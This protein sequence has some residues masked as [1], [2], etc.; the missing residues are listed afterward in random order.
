MLS[1]PT[2]SLQAASL[3][4]LSLVVG[5]MFGIWRGYDPG[6]YSASTFVE[7]HQ[8]AVHGLNA[9]LPIMGLVSIA[10]VAALAWLARMRPRVLWRY[11]AAVGA[12]AVAGLITRFGNQPLNDVVMT[13]TATPPEGWEAVRDTWWNLHL[14]RLAA[15]FLGQLLLINAVLSDSGQRADA[16][17]AQPAGTA[18]A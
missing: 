7:V 16:T 11:I 10:M 18:P 9:L 17:L 2:K 1:S 12:M 14:V 13:W 8:G 3:V 4:V 5:A 15:G 6:L